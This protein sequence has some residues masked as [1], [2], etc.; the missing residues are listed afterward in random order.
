MFVI[1]HYFLV[2]FSTI[3]NCN[4]FCRFATFLFFGIS[5]SLNQVNHFVPMHNLSK[6]YMLSVEPWA[7][8][9]CDVELTSIVV[10]IT[11]VGHGNS[12]TGIVS[13]DIVLVLES[14]PVYTLTTSAVPMSNIPS[15][16]HKSRNNSMES[17]A[18]IM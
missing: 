18:P 9:G 10:L 11:I 2:M 16:Y 14:L 3:R 13:M 6:D 17:T 12:I 4:Y 1:D 7:E 5:V 8:N 15:L